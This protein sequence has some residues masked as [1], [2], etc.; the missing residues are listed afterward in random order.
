MLLITLCLL[1]I[2]CCPLLFV[3]NSALF[4]DEWL[5]WGMHVRCEHQCV[6]DPGLLF[7]FNWCSMCKNVTYWTCHLCHRILLLH[8]KDQCTSKQFMT[9]V[10]KWMSVTTPL[11]VTFGSFEKIKVYLLFLYRGI[12]GN[13]CAK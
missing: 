2:P 3:Y 9:M 8:N 13:R 5:K 12:K 6:S 1:L 11:I 10:N 4:I 7:H